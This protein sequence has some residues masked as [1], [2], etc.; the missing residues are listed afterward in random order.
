MGKVSG[1]IDRQ[2]VRDAGLLLVL[3][4]SNISLATNTR[5]NDPY[6]PRTL[7][8]MMKAESGLPTRQMSKS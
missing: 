1:S 3:T 7:E 5:G 2:F 4:V 8:T 6:S